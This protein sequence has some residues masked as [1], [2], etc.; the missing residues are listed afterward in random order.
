MGTVLS[1]NVLLTQLARIPEAVEYGPPDSTQ[2]MH[3]R[4]L[5]ESARKTMFIL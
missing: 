2:K 4:G 1:P 3:L 5:E